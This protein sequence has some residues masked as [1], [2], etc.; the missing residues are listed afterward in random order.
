MKASI[1]FD[2]DVIKTNEYILLGK[3]MQE[4]GACAV[5]TFLTIEALDNML[6]LTRNR[7][8]LLSQARTAKGFFRKDATLMAILEKRIG[9]LVDD[10]KA[11]GI[12]ITTPETAEN[13]A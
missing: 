13:P 11:N 10:L 7:S 6:L 9:E 3:T 5:E 1:T 4:N 12:T 2:T 8:M